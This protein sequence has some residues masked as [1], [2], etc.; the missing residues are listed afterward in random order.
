MPGNLGWPFFLPMHV[1]TIDL[2]PH[3]RTKSSKLCGDFNKSVSASKPIVSTAARVKDSKVVLE[4]ISSSLDAEK[5]KMLNT[6]QE[7]TNMTTSH[8]TKE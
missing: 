6:S 7:N 1:I 8:L 3:F 5:L 2:N 4:D